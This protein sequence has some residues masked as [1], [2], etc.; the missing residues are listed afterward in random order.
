MLNTQEIYF[1]TVMGS[2]LV[3]SLICIIVITC[4][5]YYRGRRKY[6]LERYAFDNALLQTQIEIQE[7]TFKDISQE[8]HDNLGQGLTLAKLGLLTIELSESPGIKTK[9]SDVVSIITKTIQSIRDLSKSLHT[10]VIADLGLISAVKLEIDRIEKMGLLK[11]AMKIINDIPEPTPA[12]GLIVLRI[13]Q[14]G[15]QNILKHAQATELTVIFDKDGDLG[16][17]KI[18]DNGRG[19]DDKKSSEGNGLRNMRSRC[20]LIGATFLVSSGTGQGTEIAVKFPIQS[21]HA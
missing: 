15:L 3:G 18:S 7:R 20:K 5:Q 13:V 2:L 21:E 17:V 8:L 10:D 14:E 9:I 6:E 1:A 4:Y 16:V 12:N 19:M 11:T